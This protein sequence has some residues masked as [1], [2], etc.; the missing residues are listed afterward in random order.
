[1]V[2]CPVTKCRGQVNRPGAG[3]EQARSRPGAG[4]EQAR[5]RPEP[6]GF[7][8]RLVTYGPTLPPS[9]TKI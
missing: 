3:Q 5:S 2:K 9:L 6:T 4:Q 1:V 7:R 8:S